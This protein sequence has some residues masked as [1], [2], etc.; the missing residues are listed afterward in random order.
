MLAYIVSYF[1][2]LRFFVKTK[3]YGIACEERYSIQPRY[4]VM[5]HLQLEA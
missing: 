3:D 2:T 4:Q 1:L 5:K